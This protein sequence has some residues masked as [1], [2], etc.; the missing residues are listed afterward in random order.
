MTLTE[1]RKILGLEPGEDPR[2]QLG[3]FK[4]MREQIA[5]IVRTA[6]NKILAKRYREGLVEFDEALAA[7]RGYLEALGLNTQETDVTKDEV[8]SA[9]RGHAVFSEENKVKNLAGLPVLSTEPLEP[10]IRVESGKMDSGKSFRFFRWTLL[11][12]GLVGFSGW[13]YQKIEKENNLKKQ[14]RVA[15]LERQ[16][17]IFIENRRWPE[18]MESFNE[19]SGIFPDSEVVKLGRRSI[20]TGMAEEQSQFIA[21]WKGEAIAAFEASRWEDS[22]K[23]AKQVLERYPEEKEVKALLAKIA[24]AMREEQRQDAFAKVRTMLE[25]RKFDEAWGAARELTE[26]DSSDAE[27]IALMNEISEAR[28]KA[29]GDLVKAKALLAKAAKK[30]SGEFNEEVMKWLAEALALAPDDA[31]VQAMYE[32]MAAYTRTIRIPEDVKTLKKALANAKDGDRLVLAAGIWEGPVEIQA[33][34]EL[35]GVSGKTIIQC[36]AN[37]GSV[38]SLGSNVKGAHV[39]GLTLRHLSFDAGEERFSLALVKGAEAAFSD[40]RFEQGSGHGLAVT[41]GGHVKV[42]RCRF[43]ENGWN[44]IAVM[45]DGS[46]LEAEGNTLKGN[47]QNG[48]E[49]WDGAGIIVSKNICIGNSRN[50]LHLDVGSA[51][52]TVL[53][54]QMTANREFGIVL[55]SAGSGQVTGNF[56]GKNILGGMVAKAKISGVS[57]VK[58]EITA[59]LGPGLILEKGVKPESFLDNKITAN[60]G[61]EIMTETDLS[62]D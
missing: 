1:A 60:E 33:G 45:G 20:E 35:E 5:E 23:A 27:A 10:K 44:G 31:G 6:P 56:C 55:S 37:A 32:K 26:K 34:I 21:Y 39:S 38:I 51:S 36:Q 59:N 50:G 42:S 52:A 16:G 15:L 17:A 14:E 13:M 7:V 11:I 61:V 49:G 19:I 29:A 53:D 54:N 62:G 18:A 28:E 2:L 40:C 24:V 46:L 3:N 47:F 12:L 30:D 8:P 4:V 9:G 25:D 43:T 41:G 58:N 22:E 57:V 48:I